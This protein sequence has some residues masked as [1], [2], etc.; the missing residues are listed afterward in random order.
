MT[1]NS[2][3]GIVYFVHTPKILFKAAGDK[4]RNP[5]MVA[6]VDGTSGQMEE[7][8][9]F[10]IIVDCRKVADATQKYRKIMF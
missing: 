1:K 5:M 7:E 10:D 3:I 2:Q 4:I 6:N 8:E 9:I